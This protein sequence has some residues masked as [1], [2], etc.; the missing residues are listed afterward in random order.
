VF[1]QADEG[2]LNGK[3]VGLNEVGVVLNPTTVASLITHKIAINGEN[4][5]T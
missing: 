4:V 2:W 5:I 3:G 1:G